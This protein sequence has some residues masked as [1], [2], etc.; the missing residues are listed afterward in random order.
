MLKKVTDSKTRYNYFQTFSLSKRTI[1]FQ[2]NVMK[3]IL[4]TIA[5]LLVIASTTH[6]VII[7]TVA[8]LAIYV[9]LVGRVITA[10]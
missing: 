10:A 9:R 5:L 7:S 3:E 2:Q 6:H 4:A 1:S 8:V